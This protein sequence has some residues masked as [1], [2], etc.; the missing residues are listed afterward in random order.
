VK[1]DFREA[2]ARVKDQEPLTAKIAT[3]ARMTG[4]KTVN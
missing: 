2:R 4:R 3:I 1:P